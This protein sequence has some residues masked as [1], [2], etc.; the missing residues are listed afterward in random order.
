MINEFL[1]KAGHLFAII[2]FITALYAAGS[3]LWA[4]IVKD[5]I[6]RK[7][8]QKNGRIA[9]FI[10]VGSV[11]ATALTLFYII[12]NHHFEYHYAYS[13]SSKNLPVYYMIA[14]FW[15]GQ[16]GS[17]LL[18]IFW[19]CILGLILIYTSRK[20]ESPL[21]AV[22]ALVEAFLASMI[23]GVMIFGIK[24]G[25]SPFLLLRDVFDDPIFRINPDFIPADG[26]G[27]NPLLQ[28]YWMV[29]HPPTLFF[30]Y[31]TTLVPF[32]F[33]MAG[34][35]Q[36]RYKDWI[37]PALPWTIFS[38]ATLG[39]GKLMG[40]YW[41]YE[42]LNFGGYWNWDPV[43]NAV[44]IPWI[45]QVA[46]LHT[47]IIF[48]KNDTAL[49][50]SMIL[51]IAT[52]LF[53]LYATFLT[54][55]GILGNASVHSFTD[56]GLNGQLLLYLLAFMA[57]AIFL[58][59]MRWKEI[60]TTEREIS[61]YS[62][63]FWIFMGATTLCLMGFQVLIPTS[64]P[65][66]NA[67]LGWFGIE[68]NMAPPADQVGFYTKF[69][70]WGAI[71]VAVLSGTG[72]FFFWKKMEKS[73]LKNAL[74]TPILL[75]LVLSSVIIMIM[76]IQNLTYILLLTAAL[77]SIIANFK[78]LIGFRSSNIHLSGGS[79]AHIGLAMML[80][81][82]LFSSGYSKVVSL[83][84]SGL[85]YSRDLSDDIN[86]ENVLLFIDETRKMN[87]YE[88]LYKGQRVKIDGV[89]GYLKKS[90]FDQTKESHKVVAR[91]DIVKNDKV[92]IQKG[93]TVGIRA[94]NTYYEIEYRKEGKKA[95]TL[96]PRAQV[97]PSMG[98]VVSPAIR[99]AVDHDLYT[100]VSTIPDPEVEVEWSEP[101]I[102]SLRGGEQFFVND[103]VAVLENVQRIYNVDGIGLNESDVAVE[104]L[105]K[106]YG[107]N[108]TFTARP[109]FV[110]HNNMVGNIPDVVEEA[111]VKI[112]LSNI[113]PQEGSYELNLQTTQK[114]YIIMKAVEKPLINILWL[115][116]L[117]LML[118]FIMA[119]VRR[120]KE[121]RKLEVE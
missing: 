116:T 19:N 26:S 59:S 86:R 35:W 107:K 84:Q 91:E 77:Y 12:Y 49:K 109:V 36:K 39:L 37:R 102:V 51:V 41:A 111:G 55:S 57:M 53:V 82:I 40:A 43:E 18:W 63:E 46:S 28:N 34:L 7:Q 47:M 76:K 73:K 90:H 31:A 80:I 24:I 78:I 22:F 95:F 88:L 8:W 3:Y 20:W 33:L 70:L 64:I 96:Y 48:K 6:K 67:V 101:E 4:S 68:S 98:L 72:Q 112:A 30:G 54:R 9:F 83:N 16:E 14:S 50:T 58:L 25:S 94:E 85:L 108:E 103:F 29:I 117:V 87:D 114:D 93:D 32:A 52:F 13:H 113:N 115:G 71:L 66:F 44:Y 118:G 104:A 61:T 27:L 1:G 17:F 97:N 99:R 79:V 42:T 105:V 10:H 60:P 11:L 81:G 56:L 65:V 120:F 89:G 15:E 2:T 45:V 92:I 100:H 106:I 38:I 21:M 5:E 23:L 119:I 74:L 75:T 110:I 121:F 69:Q 62:R